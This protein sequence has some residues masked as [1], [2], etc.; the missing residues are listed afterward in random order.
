M[1]L[2]VEK[3]LLPDEGHIVLDDVSWEFYEH[4]LRELG[5][6]PLRVTFSDGSIEI[7]SPLPKHELWGGWINR[8]IELLCFERGIK[9]A[10]LGSTTFRSMAKRKGL[11]PDKC[12]YIQNADAG[13][14]LD[15]EFDPA[16]HLPPDLAVE[17]DI[18]SRSIPRQ[19]IYAAL[20]VKE[21]WR[22]DGADLQVMHLSAQGS[23]QPAKQSLAL[24]FLPI[25]EYT[26]FVLRMRETDQLQVLR[27]YRDWLATLQQ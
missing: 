5:D 8:L 12:F 17:I 4:V 26:G 27:E 15:A 7:L 1:T 11:E 16:V 24:P 23:Y 18:T 22:F 6:R 25:R 13:L 21:L 2:A 14:A 10:T 19:P 9:V 20:G 3:P